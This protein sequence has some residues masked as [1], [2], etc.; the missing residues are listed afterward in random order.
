MK[1]PGNFKTLWIVAFGM[2][3]ASN[4]AFALYYA[5]NGYLFWAIVVNGL[6]AALCCVCLQS[7]LE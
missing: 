1:H 3:I 2:L 7:W 5:V 4:S 6:P